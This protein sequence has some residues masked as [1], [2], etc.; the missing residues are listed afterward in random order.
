MGKQSRGKAAARATRRSRADLMEHLAESRS[1]LERSAAAYDDGYEAEAKRLAVTLRTLLHTTNRS[2]GLL[3]QLG[4]VGTLRFV[5]TAAPINP[6]NL[7]PT[8]GLLVMELTGGSGGRYVPPLAMLSPEREKPP[9]PFHGWWHGPVMKEPGRTW[10]RREF[11]LTLANKEGGAH[12]DPAL[13]DDYDRLVRRNALGFVY[14]ENDTEA[15]FTGSPVAA[16]VRQ[17]AYEVLATLDSADAAGL[18]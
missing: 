15:D 6:N 18:L 11:V 5:D 8:P 10:S 7:V 12:V 9:V 17:I 16:S 3:D 1:F 4:L 13:D 14:V 2:H